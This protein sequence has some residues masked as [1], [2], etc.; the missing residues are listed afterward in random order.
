VPLGQ[1]VRVAETDWRFPNARGLSVPTARIARR[2]GWWGQPVTRSRRGPRSWRFWRSELPPLRTQ[3][4][5]GPRRVEAGE[6]AP[7]DSSAP[8]YL[9]PGEIAARCLLLVGE[10]E[11]PLHVGCVLPAVEWPASI[12][13]GLH[14][15]RMSVV[16]C[17]L[18]HFLRLFRF[19]RR[20]RSRASGFGK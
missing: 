1:T 9:E 14:E 11:E 3:T 18:T 17:I 12:R 20:G 7:G 4:R 6:L 5:E 8:E 13:E 2:V 10:G 16:G 15:R 19:L